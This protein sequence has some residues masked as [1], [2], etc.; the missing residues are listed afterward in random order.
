MNTQEWQPCPIDMHDLDLAGE[1]LQ[2]HWEALHQGCPESFPADPAVQDA[3]RH[4]HLGEFAQA[5]EQGL[6][7]GGVGV[8][9]AAFAATIYAQYIETDD[10]RRGALFKQVMKLCEEAE[11]AGLVSANLHYIHAVAMGR[12][13]QSISIIEALAQGFGGRIKEQLQKC[14]ALSPRHPEAHATFAGWHAAISD[15]AG[16][17]MGRMLYGA[18]QDGAHEH[19]EQAVDYA[20]QALIPRTEYARGLEV[21]YG[22]KEADIR[23]HLEQ[24]MQLKALDAMERLDQQAAREHLARLT[25]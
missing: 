6:A 18:T 12:Y 16:A 15:Q 5:Y 13:G 9:P 20:P 10:K 11:D 14:L 8:V 2:Q 19:Y 4:Y 24:A 1:G 25:A 17:L 7:A 22:D 23:G 21:M 3:W